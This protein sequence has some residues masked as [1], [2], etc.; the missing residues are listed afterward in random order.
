MDKARAT[1]RLSN[2]RKA[3][4]PPHVPLTP[5]RFHRDFQEYCSLHGMRIIGCCLEGLLQYV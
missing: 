2:K 5:Q 1:R 3:E 4:E